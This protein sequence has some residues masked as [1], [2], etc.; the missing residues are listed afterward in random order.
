[1]A[2]GDTVDI[3]E[4]LATLPRIAF[5][6]GKGGVGKTS[7]ACATAVAFSDLGK[8]VLLVSTD[9]ASNL[10]EVLGTRLNGQPTAVSGTPH[11]FALNIDPIAVARAH[12]EQILA[13][14]RGVLPDASL[15]SMEEQL[16]GA[17]TV[18]IAAFNE[19]AKLL[20]D[21]T[22]TTAF[23]HVIFDTAPTGHTLRLLSLPAAWSNFISTNT[24]STSCIGP[25][26]GLEAQQSLYI[27]SLRNL[28]N[29]SLTRLILV[30]RP[31]PAALK[32][33]ARTH[34][35]LK[36]IG[37]R[38]HM[39][40]LNGIFVS[41]E[42]SDPL[43]RR[44]QERCMSAL[45]EMPESLTC[46]PRLD[47]PLLARSPL[48]I[49]DLRAAFNGVPVIRE[50]AFDVGLIGSDDSLTLGQLIDEIQAGGPGIILMMGKGGVGKTTI[51]SAAAVELAR[52]GCPV[53][54]TT[55]DPAAHVDQTI[56]SQVS[57]L[58]ISRIDPV[59]ETERYA[60]EV[61]SEAASLL[62]EQGMTFLDE[63]LRSPCTE[64]I[65]MFRAFARN[66]SR[67]RGAVRD[68]GHRAYGTHHP[69]ARCRRS[70]PTRSLAFEE[71]N[72]IRSPGSPCSTARS[73]LLSRLSNH[74]ARSNTGS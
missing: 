10:D 26:Q 1:V 62:D 19:F 66:G 49:D 30:S 13:P 67:R 9:P 60:A 16:S 69:S 6:T 57:A 18:E 32:E 47:L 39:L 73:A 45:S 11:L 25:L 37:I 21:P 65:A 70:I 34:G 27:A 17:C 68:C 72:S 54:L 22:T 38:N 56:G 8:K 12:R 48:G 2:E 3:Q 50:H 33:A 64:E 7:L 53:H 52:R 63:D 40:I 58:E 31:E 4:F 55:T 43:A 5:F 42:Y 59:L 23:E 15:A 61:R 29:E 46:L 51:A 28:A 35:E 44:F 20:A 14:Y 41:S 36:H 24:T 71:A 74:L